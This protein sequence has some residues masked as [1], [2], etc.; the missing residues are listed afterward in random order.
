MVQQWLIA[1]LQ[2]A[3]QPTPFIPPS[4]AHL[5]RKRKHKHSVHCFCSAFHAGGNNRGLLEICESS[6][7]AF[8]SPKDDISRSNG[9]LSSC[10]T[11]HAHRPLAVSP[12]P[13]LSFSLFILLAKTI[14]LA[15]CN[16]NTHL[17]LSLSNVMLLFALTS[18]L[19]QVCADMSDS[20][21]PVFHYPWGML[22]WMLMA[23]SYRC[24]R[25]TSAKRTFCFFN[26][27]RSKKTGSHFRGEKFSS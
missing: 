9:G 14:A 7:S 26:I 5:Y 16:T 12:S 22:D 6:L 2:S 24:L 3:T 10:L 4:F 18:S 11:N 23:L 21:S 27:C 13:S 25:N 20:V 15:L 17:W 19:P 8:C 1:V